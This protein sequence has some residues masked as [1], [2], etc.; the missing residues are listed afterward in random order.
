MS[1]PATR[2]DERA[3]EWDANPARVALARGDVEA[4]RAADPLRPDMSVI[5]FGACTGLISL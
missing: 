2:F 5:D 1:A 4:D 3:A